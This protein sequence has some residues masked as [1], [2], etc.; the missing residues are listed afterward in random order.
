MSLR[1]GF[2]N[3]CLHKARGRKRIAYARRF[4]FSS[5]ITLQP[6]SSCPGRLQPHLLAHLTQMPRSRE[7]LVWQSSA[8]CC[9]LFT[10]LRSLQCQRAPTV[11]GL[12]C[13]LCSSQN[14]SRATSSSQDQLSHFSLLNLTPTNPIRMET[15]PN[16]PLGSDS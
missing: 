11:C 10:S 1:D 15:E 2:K 7:S 16:L 6:L 4:P 13:P 3:K 9:H 5:S 12:T 14:G 8:I